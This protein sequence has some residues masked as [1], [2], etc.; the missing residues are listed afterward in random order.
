MLFLGCAIFFVWLIRVWSSKE[1]VCCVYDPSVCVGVLKHNLC[2]RLY[3]YLVLP[4]H[5]WILVAGGGTGRFGLG[6][7]FLL[8]LAWIWCVTWFARTRHRAV[9][10][11]GSF[12]SFLIVF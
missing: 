10:V 1:Y 12:D 4:L 7:M 5:S 11:V 9:A 2:Q 6:G 3:C 8:P